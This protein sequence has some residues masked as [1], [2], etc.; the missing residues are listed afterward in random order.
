MESKTNNENIEKID[1]ISHRLPK[2][3]KDLSYDQCEE[4]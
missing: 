4:E 3:Q 1:S 2:N